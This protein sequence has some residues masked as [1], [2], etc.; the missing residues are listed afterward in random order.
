MEGYQGS[1]E[2]TET[3]VLCKFLGV[4]FKPRFDPLRITLCCLPLLAFEQVTTTLQGFSVAP[5]LSVSSSA[6]V[7]ALGKETPIAKAT[8]HAAKLLVERVGK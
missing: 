4:D 5:P 3:L 8:G 7:A 2:P 6:S 1:C